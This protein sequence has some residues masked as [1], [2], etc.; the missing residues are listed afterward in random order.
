[1]K[2]Q[3]TTIQGFQPQDTR[4]RLQT[5]DRDNLSLHRINNPRH[6]INEERDALLNRLLPVAASAFQQEIDS[7]FRRDVE[8]H[9]FNADGLYIVQDEDSVAVAFRMWDF[10]VYNF[11][12]GT[13]ILYLAGMCVHKEWQHKGIG[14]EL[15]HCVLREDLR[16]C[17]HDKHAFAPLPP[18]PYVAFRTQNPIMKRCFDKAVGVE[19]YPRLCDETI[20]DDIANVGALIAK[21]YGDAHFEPETMISRGVYGHSLYGYRPVTSDEA[22]ESLFSRMDVEAGDGMVCVWRRQSTH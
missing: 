16:H 9:I 14:E 1:M 13:D 10:L 17:L 6:I 19:S 7:D 8:N 18:A 15:L 5:G 20:P 12:A 3:D 4:I 22:Y 11:V 21:R 2:T